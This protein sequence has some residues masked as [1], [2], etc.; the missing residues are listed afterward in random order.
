MLLSFLSC[1]TNGTQQGR[2]MLA[3]E[4]KITFRA[5]GCTGKTHR[6]RQAKESLCCTASRRKTAAIFL[7][8]LTPPPPTYKPVG[9]FNRGGATSQQSQ[10]RFPTVS[11]RGQH[12]LYINEYQK[13]FVGG[14]DGRCVGLKT[15]PPSCADYL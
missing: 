14:K 6:V 2:S 3:G 1:V 15:L 4:S 11:L 10:V 13:Y 7:P 5:Y 8:T 9:E 12:S